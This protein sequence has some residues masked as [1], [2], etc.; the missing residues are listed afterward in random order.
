MSNA[1]FSAGAMYGTRTDA[2]GIGPDQFGL[3]QNVSVDFNRDVKTL[4]GERQFPA[5]S[6]TGMST[7]TGRAAYA[8]IFGGVYAHLF[9]GETLTDN[10]SLTASEGES[11]TIPGSPTYTVLADHMS[12]WEE[13]LGV[14]LTSTGARMT[15]TSSGSPASGEYT[16]SGGTY[17]FNAAQASLGVKISYLY[18]AGS[19]KLITINNQLMGVTP[20]FSLV[21]T[22]PGK[23]QTGNAPFSLKLN[24]C[25]ATK[26]SFPLRLG[27]FALP[28]FEFSGYAD[29]S[30]VIG[31]IST[32][33]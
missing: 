9:F 1:L 31:N 33:E 28:E 23:T 8:R 32:T 26:L 25:T 2:S 14:Y 22:N 29:A 24:S 20:T 13:D 10:S 16:V 27:E 5:L 19:G 7:I 21:L 3:L 11:H 15:Y 30:D 4:H 18:T 17:T 12:N 6:A